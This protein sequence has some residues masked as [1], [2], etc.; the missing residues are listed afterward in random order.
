MPPTLHATAARDGLFRAARGGRGAFDHVEATAGDVQPGGSGLLEDVGPESQRRQRDSRRERCGTGP[1]FGV[2]GVV[3]MDGV[4]P[5]Q[6]MDVDGSPV[7]VVSGWTHSGKTTLTQ[8][9]SA[10]GL[11]G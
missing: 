11:P 1:V 2:W 8:R 7:V 4:V 10:G 9:L 5:R 3:V 6:A